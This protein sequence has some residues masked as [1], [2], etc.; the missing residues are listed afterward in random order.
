M[1]A[2]SIT[3]YVALVAEVEEVLKNGDTSEKSYGEW[4]LIMDAANAQIEIN[5]DVRVPFIPG[6]YYAITLGSSNGTRYIGSVSAGL[7]ATVKELTDNMQW[8]IVPAEDG[9]T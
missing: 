9:E 4:F 2:D 1:I 5:T 7:N 3:E 6:C 8:R